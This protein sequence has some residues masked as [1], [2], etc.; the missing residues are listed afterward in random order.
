MCNCCKTIPK[1]E[2]VARAILQ[3]R[4]DI[5][6]PQNAMERFLKELDRF[7]K[8]SRKSRIVVGGP[9]KQEKN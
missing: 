1:S 2:A 6:R 8:S 7:E 9:Y 3:Q 4:R 5:I